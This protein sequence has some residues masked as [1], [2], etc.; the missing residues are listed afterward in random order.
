MGDTEGP[1]LSPQVGSPGAGISLGMLVI[2]GGSF[3]HQSLGVWDSWT[4]GPPVSRTPEGRRVSAAGRS[5]WPA[6]CT[7]VLRVR[8]PQ[9]SESRPPGCCVSTR[10]APSAFLL[11]RGWSIPPGSFPGGGR[12]SGAGAHPQMSSCSH[13]P[14]PQPTGSAHDCPIPTSGL[15][16]PLVGTLCFPEQ[17]GQWK[18]SHL[19]YSPQTAQ[20]PSLSGQQPLH[21]SLLRRHDIDHSLEP[22]S[23]NE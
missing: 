20:G 7:R 10:V 21:S 3:D 6:L 5:E 11:P 2:S 23:E 19:G 15:G 12:H 1:L 16:G 13:S 22:P 17:T 18:T 14:V 8:S 9:H 4:P